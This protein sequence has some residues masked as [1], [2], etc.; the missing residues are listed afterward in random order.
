MVSNEALVIL[1]LFLLIA[2]TFLNIFRF[3]I[4]CK[5]LIRYAL[6]LQSFFIIFRLNYKFNH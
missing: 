1:L 5:V 2:R 6:V 3:F 4:N